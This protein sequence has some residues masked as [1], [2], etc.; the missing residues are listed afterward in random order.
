VVRDFMEQRQLDL[1]EVS[2][3]EAGLERERRQQRRT[4]RR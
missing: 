2:E 3:I 4:R 1:I